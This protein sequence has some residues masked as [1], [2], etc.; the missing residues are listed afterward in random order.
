MAGPLQAQMHD[1]AFIGVWKLNVDR[2]V[3]T[4]GPRPPSDM[5]LLYQFAPLPDG[6]TRFT[7]TGRNPAGDLTFQMSVFRIDGEQRPVYNL[8][9]LQALMTSGERTNVMRSYRRIDAGTV[10]FQTYTD[11]VSSGPVVRQLLPDGDTYVQRPASGEG[12]VLVFE[13]LP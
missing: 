3:Y 1:N 11:G 2:S 8:N 13:R 7:L 9:T 5:M 4:P 6:S 10:E 12:N